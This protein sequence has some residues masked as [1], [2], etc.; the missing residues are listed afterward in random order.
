MAA[1]LCA[2]QKSLGIRDYSSDPARKSERE[3]TAQPGRDFHKGMD[4]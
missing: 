2:T 4:C 1:F 3:Q